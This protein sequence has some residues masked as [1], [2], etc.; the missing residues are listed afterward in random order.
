[1]A[2]GIGTAMQAGSPRTKGDEVKLMFQLFDLDHDGVVTKDE[3]KRVLQSLDKDIWTD[4]K[5][6]KVLGAYDSNGDENLQFTEFW[7]WVCGHGGKST[8]DFKPAL[9]SRAIEED[10][11]RR[12]VLQAKLDKE[13]ELRQAREA[14]ESAKAQKLQERADGR[15]WN[16]EE[17]VQQQMQIGIS[18]EVANEMF[19][20]GD[21]DRDGDIDHQEKIWLAQE[22]VATTKQ[23]RGLY[24]NVAS[25]GNVDVKGNLDLKGM[26]DS[27]MDAVVQAFLSWDKDGN[28]TITPEELA[29]VLKTLNPTMGI[30]TV[31][32]LCQEIDVNKDGSID[33]QEFVGWLSG[34]HLKKKKMKKKAKEE[35]DARLALSLHRKRVSE[36]AELKL[37]AEFEEMQ[38]RKLEEF[39]ARKKLAV[40][41]GTLNRDKNTCKAC[42]SK[43]GWLCHGCG[44]VSFYDECVHGCPDRKYGWS[45]IS[46]KC[47]KKKCGCKKKPEFWAKINVHGLDRLSLGVRQMIEADK[48]AAGDDVAA[49]TPGKPAASS[50]NPEVVP[51]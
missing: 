32:A 21:E 24:Q 5:V 22:C 39:C 13:N 40:G 15:R 8:E 26:D 4:A 37:Q 33:I 36:A 47:E 1:M 28:G 38:H 41:C 42:G 14:K 44:F 30:A 11:E 9:L 25:A 23:I 20:K 49:E 34:E 46:G 27:G 12:A 16:R 6:E 48:A 18:R 7:G 29:Q 51:E 17:F 50:D 3:M 19:N 35:Q 10:R 31:E 43:H 45:C 2:A